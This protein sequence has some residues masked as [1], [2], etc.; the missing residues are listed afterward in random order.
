MKRK[1]RGEAAGSAEADNVPGLSLGSS[2]GEGGGA[3]MD[4]VTSGS[5]L[6]FY[7]FLKRGN[8]MNGIKEQK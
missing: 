8:E 2:F 6:I 3:D 1:N 4:G 5:L 7:D